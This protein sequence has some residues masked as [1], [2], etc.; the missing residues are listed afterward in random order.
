V[1]FAVAT[2]VFGG[3]WPDW[4]RYLAYIRLY[5]WNGFST[6]L[7]EPWSLGYLI[8]ALYFISAAGFVFVAL[9]QQEFV[10]AK[11]VE[12]TAIAATTAFGILSYTYFLGRSHP[13]NLHH[14]APPAI[15][16]F[17]LW[18]SLLARH[19]PM[20]NGTVRFAALVFVGWAAAAVIV[21]Q[22]QETH[23][24]LLRS[25]LRQIVQLNPRLSTR[26]HALID[27]RQRPDD[28]RAVEAEQLLD[29]FAPG[30]SRVAVVLQVDLSTEALIR[31]HRGNLLPMAVPLQES[32]LPARSLSLIEKRLSRLEPGSVVLT[33][34]G[35]LDQPPHYHYRGAAGYPDELG[36]VVLS[37]IRRLF[38]YRVAATT[39]NGLVLL[40]L[41]AKASGAG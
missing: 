24:S 9:E 13:N 14:I 11:R 3:V 41:E 22:P 21:Q 20:G 25:P 33:E 37:E 39:P 38:R 32:L 5:G 16:L 10:S 8:A 7:I 40:I 23:A 31:A 17:V 35:Y 12:L 6:L 34:Q 19:T 26:A 15:V 30:Q 29:R 2:R 36:V 27:W 28:P 18:V 1:V 4:G